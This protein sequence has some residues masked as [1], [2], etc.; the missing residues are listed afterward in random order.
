MHHVWEFPFG[1]FH[2]NLGKTMVLIW[3]GTWNPFHILGITCLL[4]IISKKKKKKKG[5]MFI[6]M[7]KYADCHN[8][9]LQNLDR[10]DGIL[11]DFDQISKFLESIPD[12]LILFPPFF[13][14]FNS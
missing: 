10:L 14:T 1:K 6:N 2:W 12:L 9:N 3:F 7:R 8:V 11:M 4:T 5:K 13:S